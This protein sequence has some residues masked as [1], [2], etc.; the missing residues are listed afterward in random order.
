MP[1]EHFHRQLE[2]LRSQVAAIGGM[3]D[4]QLER[5]VRALEHRDAALAQ[6]VVDG[7]AEVNARCARAQDFCVVLLAE[8]APQAGDLRLILAA[9]AIVAELERIADHATGIAKVVERM[10]AEPSDVQ[11][12]FDT[13]ASRARR[14]LEAALSA[15]AHEGA[16][17]ARAVGTADDEVDEL[18]EAAYRL[19]IG[20][21]QG[22]HDQLARAVGMLWATHDLERVADRATNIAE[23][24][25]YAATGERVELNAHAR[26]TTTASGADGAQER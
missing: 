1:R 10:G 14:M 25:I 12:L 20:R 23:Q 3:A 2:E 8:Q 9:L 4:D 15:F 21:A 17:A 11:P 7:D 6:A 5:A 26:T 22:D 24:V 18:Q 19:L 13:M 16:T